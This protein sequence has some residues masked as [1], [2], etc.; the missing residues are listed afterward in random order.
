[1]VDEG[2]MRALS[3]QPSLHGASVGGVYVERQIL[4]MNMMMKGQT[5]W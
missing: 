1:M 5:T 3:S 2:K 4:C